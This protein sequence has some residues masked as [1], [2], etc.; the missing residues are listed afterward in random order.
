ME[1]KLELNYLIIIAL[2]CEFCNKFLYSIFDTVVCQYGTQ[3]HRMT[4]LEF[5]LL[6]AAGS[7]LNFLQTGPLFSWL[8]NTH[9]CSAPS[10]GT[11]AGLLGS[12]RRFS[13]SHAALA[14]ALC[15]YGNRAVY[16]A[17]SVLL[18]VGYG[19][20]API[21]PTILAVRARAAVNGRR[22]ARTP[23]ARRRRRCCEPAGSWR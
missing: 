23:R 1:E 8:F 20:Y 18:L 22:R 11:V 14:C 7:A 6:S 13:S 5:T 15:L 21:T 19:V 10:I 4:A 16:D 17:G 3:K 2:I 9:Q 12:S